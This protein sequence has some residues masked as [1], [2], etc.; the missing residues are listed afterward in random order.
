M[1]V[2]LITGRGGS[3]KS[4]VAAELKRRGHPALDAD[5]VPGLA[6]SEDLGTGLPIEVD[7]SGFVD[8]SKVG[9]NWQ[10]KALDELLERSKDLFL[11]GSA[12]NQLTFHPRFDKVFVLI[13]DPGTHRHRLQTRA[14]RYGKNPRMMEEILALQQ[15]FAT[16]A[17]RSGAIGI[18]AT[19]PVS[20]IVDEILGH[21]EHN[22]SMAK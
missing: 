16:E 6:R 20:K 9:W 8:Y 4:T 18:D 13:L 3:G 2:Y 5:E 22:R 10:N 15:S 14:S 12:S 1:G 21:A 17:L 7:Y 19:Q 11:C